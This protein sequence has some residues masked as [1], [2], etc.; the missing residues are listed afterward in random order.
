M[1]WTPEHCHASYQ[2][3]EFLYTGIGV[4]NNTTTDCSG[5]QNWAN[6]LMA[7]QGCQAMEQQC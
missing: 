2:E 4:Q 1:A 6:W 5:T 7:E 3:G